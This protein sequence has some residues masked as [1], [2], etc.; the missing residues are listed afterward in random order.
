MAWRIVDETSRHRRIQRSDYFNYDRAH[1]IVSMAP[2]FLWSVPRM[3]TL[4]FVL[5]HLAPG[6]WQASVPRETPDDKWQ[7]CSG[8][9]AEPGNLLFS[10]LGFP[11]HGVAV[12]Y[13]LTIP[14]VPSCLVFPE[15]VQT[16]AQVKITCLVCY[17]CNLAN[18]APL[19]NVR[20]ILRFII[21]LFNFLILTSLY[22]YL[23]KNFLTS[24]YHWSG[25]RQ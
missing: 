5:A 21:Y 20:T 10:G 22:Y 15:S 12:Y 4:A 9:A 18:V 14:R 1:Y 6:C 11:M 13:L 17:C 24:E 19:H 16:A 23:L 2:L 3:H 25:K 7:Q 8:Y